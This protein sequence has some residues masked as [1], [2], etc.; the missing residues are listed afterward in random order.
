MLAFGR[1]TGFLGRYLPRALQLEQ[2]ASPV[3]G[4]RMPFANI[5]QRVFTPLQ[6]TPHESAYVG[7]GGIGLWPWVGLEASA[8]CSVTY[9]RM[10]FRITCAAGLS[11]RRQASRNSLRSSLSTRILKPASLVFMEAV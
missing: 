7:G 10:N 3:G 5:L 9:A 6:H 8:S 2:L 1:G 11:C 4:F